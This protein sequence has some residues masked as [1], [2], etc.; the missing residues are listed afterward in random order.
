MGALS[1]PKLEKF[2]QALLVNIAHGMPRSKAAAAAAKTAGYSGSSLAS[3]ARRKAGLAQVKARM[4]ELAAP[5]RQKVERDVIATVETAINKL[6]E[7]GSAQ[8]GDDAIKVSDQISAWKLVAQIKG[9]MA[10]EKR[11][12]AMEATVVR[13]PAVAATSDEWKAR[14]EPGGS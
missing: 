1:D 8:L 4:A 7:I 2:A 9:W 12:I 6:S 10:P 3:N 14:H 5:V 13:V 11:D